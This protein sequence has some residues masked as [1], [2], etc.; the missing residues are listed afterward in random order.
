MDPIHSV[1]KGLPC[2][3]LYFGPVAYITWINYLL[4]RFGYS[5]ESP[6]QGDSTEWPQQ[7]FFTEKSRKLSFTCYQILYL[8]V[9][10]WKNTPE[11]TVNAKENQLDVLW[12]P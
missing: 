6:R 7:M 12:I 5:L 4:I 9:L 8:P 1:M 10:L 3:L 11:T 2:M